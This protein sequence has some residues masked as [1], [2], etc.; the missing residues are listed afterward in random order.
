MSQYS[1]SGIRE[2]HSKLS[3]RSKRAVQKVLSDS[4]MTYCLHKLNN[5]A[6]PFCGDGVVQNGEVKKRLFGILLRPHPSCS[7]SLFDICLP[8][9]HFRNV[10]VGQ[11]RIVLLKSHVAYHQ[12]E[13]QR[14]KMNASLRLEN[15][16]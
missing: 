11:Q 10:I 9:F 3:P 13:D 12:A 1:N 15:T 7:A 16:C 14:N 8:I 5:N 6:A 4:R 2:N